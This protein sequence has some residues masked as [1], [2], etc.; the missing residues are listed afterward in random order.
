MLLGEDWVEL[1]TEVDG[2]LF[3]VVDVAGAPHDNPQFVVEVEELLLLLVLVL[4]DF[5]V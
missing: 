1:E 3:V 2:V 4:L 5:W